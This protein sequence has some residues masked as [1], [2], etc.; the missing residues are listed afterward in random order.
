MSSALSPR[1][2]GSSTRPHNDEIG[3]HGGEH[4]AV[5]GLEPFPNGDHEDDR[6]DAP[7]YAEHGQCAPELMRPDVA[8]RLNEDFA[9]EGHLRAEPASRLPSVPQAPLSA[10]RWRCRS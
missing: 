6:G 2:A 4:V 10:G 7:G 3:A 9:G 5:S 1:L 8:Q